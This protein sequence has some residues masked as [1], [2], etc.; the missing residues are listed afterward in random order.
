MGVLQLGRAWLIRQG[1]DDTSF[2]LPAP[3]SAS[4]C[5]YLIWKRVGKSWIRENLTRRYNRA[6]GL[7]SI[8]IKGGARR[9][10]ARVAYIG[11]EFELSYFM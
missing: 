11:E 1:N 6:E 7:S 4:S 3:K 9:F 10:R 2:D 8:S 5:V